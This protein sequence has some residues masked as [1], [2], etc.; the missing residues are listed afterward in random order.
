MKKLSICLL[1]LL[2]M[3]SCGNDIKTNSTP[4]TNPPAETNL[5]TETDLP[6]GEPLDII[7]Y[8]GNYYYGLVMSWE[9]DELPDDYSCIGQFK[10]V[11]DFKEVRDKELKNA[12]KTD[13]LTSTCSITE[14]GDDIFH[15]TDEDGLHYFCVPTARS[16]VYAGIYGASTDP[17]NSY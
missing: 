16:G 7:A 9:L 1:L 11:K 4:E 12:P 10:G 2:T 15:Y 3:C 5:P 13:E 6:T 17:K 8:D 14:T